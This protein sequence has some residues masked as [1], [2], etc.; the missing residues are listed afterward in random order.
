MNSKKMDL[1]NTNIADTKESIMDELRVVVAD[2]EEQLRAATDHAVEEAIAASGRI[3]ENLE[4]VEES[5]VEAEVSMIDL[6]RNTVKGTD[7][8]VRDN[9]WNWS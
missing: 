6:T 9:V 7:Q 2:A 3:Q 5:M 1:K 4:V 8:Y